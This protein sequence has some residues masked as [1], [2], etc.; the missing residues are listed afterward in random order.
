VTLFE[1]APRQEPQVPP[2]LPLVVAET[3]EDGTLQVAVDGMPHGECPIERTQLA[4]ALD[5][6]TAARGCPVRVEVR[7]ADGSAFVDVVVPAAFASGADLTPDRPTI[8]EPAPSPPADSRSTTGVLRGA[9][10]TPGESVA[11][12]VVVS[13][14]MAREDGTVSFRVPHAVGVLGEVVL[15]GRRSGVTSLPGDRR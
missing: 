15:L 3:L 7:E 9:G 11:V 5:A 1:T 8:V 4:A 12:T 6:I 2:V 10:F 13:D 14:Q